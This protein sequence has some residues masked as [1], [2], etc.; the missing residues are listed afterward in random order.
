LSAVLL[1]TI[2]ASSSAH[3][4]DV[5]DYGANPRDSEDDTD[6]IAQAVAEACELVRAQRP[7][8]ASIVGSAPVVYFPAGIY[9]L[10][11]QIE[12]SGFASMRGDGGKSMIRWMDAETAGQPGAEAMFRIH[13]YTNRIENLKFIGGSCGL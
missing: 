7:D 9:Y 3:V 4:I 5:T 12:L 1:L 6:A 8:D 2:A 11:R 13:A 10:S